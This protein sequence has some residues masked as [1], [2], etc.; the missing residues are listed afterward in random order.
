MGLTSWGQFCFVPEMGATKKSCARLGKGQINC[1]GWLAGVP[2]LA[3][4][5]AGGIALAAAQGRTPPSPNHP[6][7]IRGKN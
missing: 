3:S 5:V 4:P 1:G 7:N 2:L 6:D